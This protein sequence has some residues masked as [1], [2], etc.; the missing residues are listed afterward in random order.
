LVN[1]AG[2]YPPGPTEGMTEADFD[3]VFGVNVKAPFFLVGRLAPP[4][5]ERG[6]G[7]IINVTIRPARCPGERSQ[8][9][10]HTHRRHRRIRREPRAAGRHRTGKARGYPADIAV[11]FFATD[12]SSFVHGAV[13]PVDGGRTAI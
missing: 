11:V 8:P 6:A 7:A 4:M 2:I 13:L 3:A 10:A 9:R 1:D 5:A 12:R